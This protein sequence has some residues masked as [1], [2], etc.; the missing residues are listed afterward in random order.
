M[1]GCLINKKFNKALEEASDVLIAHYVF[2]PDNDQR[3]S[4]LY[5]KEK[6][7]VLGYHY[8][9]EIFDEYN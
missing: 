7:S 5:C 3:K 9:N 8:G 1:K 6:F 2:N 4:M